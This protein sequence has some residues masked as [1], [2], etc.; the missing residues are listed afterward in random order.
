MQKRST[1]IRTSK[2][3]QLYL[4][5]ESNISILSNIGCIFKQE[6]DWL[7][8]QGYTYKIIVDFDAS[9]TQYSELFNI[10]NYDII[11]YLKFLEEDQA[12]HYK[13]VWGEY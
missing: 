2:T 11:I 8:H 7:N 9:I 4:S 1:K 3:L 12:V 10:D 13:L 6:L 5:D